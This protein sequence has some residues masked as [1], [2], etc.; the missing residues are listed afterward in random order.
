M[1]P[2]L[3]VGLISFSRRKIQY[4]MLTGTDADT[5]KKCQKRARIDGCN[6]IIIVGTR[7]AGLRSN[8]LVAVLV[9]EF[10]LWSC[11]LLAVTI[12]HHIRCPQLFCW[13]LIN[14]SFS[15]DPLMLASVPQSVSRARI[16]FSPANKIIFYTPSWR[17]SLK[18]QL[19]WSEN[20]RSA[21]KNRFKIRSK[22]SERDLF[23]T[24]VSIRYCILCFRLLEQM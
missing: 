5:C 13:V 17:K 11:A 20:H 22:Y 8:I 2:L 9:I 19:Q 4:R 7:L 21:R 23:A 10:Q 18:P 16:L 3:S 24:P 6:H 15:T 12:G 14:E 1:F